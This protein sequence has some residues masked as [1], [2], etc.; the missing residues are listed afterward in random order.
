MDPPE[1]LCTN[2][3]ATNGTPT[4]TPTRTPVV[5]S[6]ISPAPKAMIAEE[7]PNPSVDNSPPVLEALVTNNTKGL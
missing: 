1:F 7:P 6:D 2:D 5:I 3:G 4:P